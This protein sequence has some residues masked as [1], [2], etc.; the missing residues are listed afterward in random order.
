MS[1]EENLRVSYK[2]ILVDQSRTGTVV[3]RSRY[4]ATAVTVTVNMSVC[5]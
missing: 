1:Y 3:V 2:L 4:R 5:V